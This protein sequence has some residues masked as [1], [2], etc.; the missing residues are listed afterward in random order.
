MQSRVLTGTMVGRSPKSVI[1]K[2]KRY[3]WLA[4]KIVAT[5]YCV[6][7][8]LKPKRKE[9]S[10]QLF[11]KYVTLF[12]STARFHNDQFKGF[13]LSIIFLCGNPFQAYSDKVYQVEC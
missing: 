13:I 4:D 11:I 6:F 5:S 1:P 8:A 12:S 7:S 10:L 9:K 2:V 3:L